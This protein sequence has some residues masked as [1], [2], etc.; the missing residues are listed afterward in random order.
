M[1][2]IR[3]TNMKN[4]MALTGLFIMMILVSCSSPEQKL[5]GIWKVTDVQTGFDENDVTP[6]MLKQAVDLQKQ[7]YFR[8][9]NDSA[10]VIISNKNTHEAIWHFN[11]ETSEITY[12]FKG[13]P[14]PQT[15]VNILGKYQDGKIIQ[16]ST[17]PLGIITTTYERK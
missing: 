13:S 2:G 1:F 7:T 17:T 9:L 5:T 15:L 11:K 3:K 6:E 4:T 12:S 16:Q 14:G 8:I 10:M